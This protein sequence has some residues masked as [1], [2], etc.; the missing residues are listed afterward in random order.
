MFYMSKTPYERCCFEKIL[1][2]E[3]WEQIGGCWSGSIEY[4]FN[5][6]LDT[7]NVLSNVFKNA[8]ILVPWLFCFDLAIDTGVFYHLRIR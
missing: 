8:F 7:S 1:V 5:L 2:I 4:S 3:S 6:L